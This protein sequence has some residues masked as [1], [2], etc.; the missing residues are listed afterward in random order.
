MIS[1][2][3]SLALA[4]SLFFVAASADEGVFEVLVS[5]SMPGEM[6]VVLT[7]LTLVTSVTFIAVLLACGMRDPV[8]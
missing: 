3:R 2:V 4:S 6:L 7:A 1:K 8:L 5:S